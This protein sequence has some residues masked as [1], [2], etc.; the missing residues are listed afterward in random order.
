MCVFLVVCWFF[1]CLLVDLVVGCLSVGQFGLSLCV[2]RCLL[3]VV[4]YV[5]VVDCCSL[6]LIQ[7]RA[8]CC[9]VVFVC[10]VAVWLLLVDCCALRAHACHRL[11]CCMVCFGCLWCVACCCCFVCGVLAVVCCL[12]VVR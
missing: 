4:C 3:S 12:V 7:L 1:C 11:V 2:A 9:F 6:L 8:A 5:I 10:V